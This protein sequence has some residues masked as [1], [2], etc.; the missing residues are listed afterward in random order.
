MYEE[1]AISVSYS[2][3]RQTKVLDTEIADRRYC[4]LCCDLVGYNIVRWKSMATIL[5]LLCKG[6]GNSEITIRL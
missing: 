4:D 3:G 2:R 6:C 5:G 1:F